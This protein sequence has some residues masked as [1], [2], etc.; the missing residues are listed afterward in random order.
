MLEAFLG[1]VLG[2][3]VVILGR[4][5]LSHVPAL[6]LLLLGSVVLGAMFWLG[7]VPAR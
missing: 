4:P 7:S 1:V 3:G 5:R 2:F 6:G